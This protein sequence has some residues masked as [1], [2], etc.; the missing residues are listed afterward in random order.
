MEKNRQPFFF[1][2]KAILDNV[3]ELKIED[4]TTLISYTII[5][6]I[7]IVGRTKSCTCQ[8]SYEILPRAVFG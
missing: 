2:G 4:T 1:L 3:I 6:I 7:I 5:I 8:E